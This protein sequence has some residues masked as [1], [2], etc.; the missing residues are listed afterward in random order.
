MNS[1]QLKFQPPN[2]S[3]ISQCNTGVVIVDTTRASA[4]SPGS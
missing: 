3:K 2:F 4:G 1:P